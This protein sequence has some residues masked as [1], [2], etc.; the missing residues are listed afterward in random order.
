MARWLPPFGVAKAQDTRDI[1]RQALGGRGDHQRHERFGGDERQ[2]RTAVGPLGDRRRD[3]A[4][5]RRRGAV[6][7]PSAYSLAH[8]EPRS[9][10]GVVAGSASGPREQQRLEWHSL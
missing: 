2:G 7:A 9:V 8:G 4:E 5:S 10:R 1:T 3:P 6:L